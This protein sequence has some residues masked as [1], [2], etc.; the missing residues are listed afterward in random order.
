MHIII[1]K[2]FDLFNT[3]GG[4]AYIGEPVSQLEHALQA[5]LAARRHQARP[6]MITAALLHDIG[7]F[8]HSYDEDCAD[9]NIDSQHEKVGEQFL[10]Q[11]FKEEVAELVKH[12][13]DAKRYLTATN[14]KYFKN[15]SSA[16]LKSLQLQGGPM[17]KEE[18]ELFAAHPLF[19]DILLLRRWDEGAKIPN[20]ELPPITDFYSELEASLK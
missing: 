8:L 10:R 5:G 18:V 19:N 16:S 20:K 14:E 15:L 6:E 3:Q 11:H 13:V 7:H 17:Q 9:E 2:I 1:G 12:H 4:N